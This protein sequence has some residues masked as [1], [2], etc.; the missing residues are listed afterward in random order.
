MN[1]ALARA[2]SATRFPKASDGPATVGDTTPTGEFQRDILPGME[3]KR[4]NGQKSRRV[5]HGGTICPRWL[6]RSRRGHEVFED[7]KEA[8]IATPFTDGLTGN[9]EFQA[10]AAQK[11]TE[12]KPLA[13]MLLEADATCIHYGIRRITRVKQDGVERLGMEVS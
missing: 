1:N 3:I 6:N 12:N 9:T 4:C 7:G 11:M 8:V 13:A 2:F 10:Y 5:G